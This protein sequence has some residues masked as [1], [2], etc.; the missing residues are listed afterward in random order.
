MFLSHD[1]TESSPLT[2][3]FVLVSLLLLCNT[4]GLSCFL[5]GPRVLGCYGTFTKTRMT[6]RK[7]SG[8]SFLFSWCCWQDKMMQI[9]KKVRFVRNWNKN[10]ITFQIIQSVWPFF[11]VL[12]YFPCQQS[13][14]AQQNMGVSAIQPAG[15]SLN[16]NKTNNT[17]RRNIRMKGL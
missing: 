2:V 5:R 16:H 15:V 13:D 10:K 4:D 7:P 14:A 8:M 17:R 6:C 12:C 3:L 9:C 1:A 11:A